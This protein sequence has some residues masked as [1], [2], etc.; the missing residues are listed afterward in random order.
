[1]GSPRSQPGHSLHSRAHFSAP[2]PSQAHRETVPEERKAMLW[3]LKK[4]K[5]CVVYSQLAECLSSIYEVL[6]FIS[7]TT[8]EIII[9]I[10]LKITKK[11]LKDT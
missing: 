2:E 8:K 5:S 9:K 4:N 1:M 7:N 3:G 11:V 10:N 6:G